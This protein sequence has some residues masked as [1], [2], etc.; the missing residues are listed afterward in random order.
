[1]EIIAFDWRDLTSE[2]KVKRFLRFTKEGIEKIEQETDLNE[3]CKVLLIKQLGKIYQQKK[4]FLSFIDYLKD[5]K[6]QLINELK[7]IKDNLSKQYILDLQEKGIPVIPTIGLNDSK[8]LEELRQ[9][10]FTTKFYNESPKD[11][12]IKPKIFGEQGQGVRKLSSFKTEEEFQEYFESNKPLIVQPLIEEINTKGENGLIFLNDKFIHG[13]NK[14][15]GEFKINF[16]NKVKY[17]KYIPNEKTLKVCRN[18][19][20]EMPYKA[21]HMRIDFIPHKDSILIGE[22]E[23]INPASYL[24][25]IPEVSEGFIKELE[26]LLNEVYSKNDN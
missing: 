24:E 23:M 26:I 21:H 5:F 17:T 1:M 2:L 14:F 16:G 12:V 19:I 18:I 8:T 20:K 3:L 6:G 4:E 15:T 22:V 25:D 11:L 10:N 9:L 7:T 13:V